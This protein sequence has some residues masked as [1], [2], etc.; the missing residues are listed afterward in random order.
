M[1]FSYLRGATDFH[2]G[3]NSLSRLDSFYGRLERCVSANSTVTLFYYDQLFGLFTHHQAATK[4]E[5]TRMNI[6]G[7]RNK[8]HGAEPVVTDNF[9]QCHSRGGAALCATARN[10]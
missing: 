7:A 1:V 9:V 6:S 2:A 5:P 10:V 4:I 8:N 3:A